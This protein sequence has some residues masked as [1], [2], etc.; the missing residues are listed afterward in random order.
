[1]A[2]KYCE[3]CGARLKNFLGVWKCTNIKAHDRLGT[4]PTRGGKRLRL[5]P[6]GGA[7]PGAGRKP[8]KKENGK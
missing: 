5:R 6:K 8:K 2:D 4:T 1:M 3:I 7:Q